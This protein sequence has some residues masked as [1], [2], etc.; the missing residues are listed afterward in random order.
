MGR[1]G[2]NRGLT[3]LEESTMKLTLLLILSF[4][5]YGC[6]AKKMAAKNA[7][8][9]LEY[10]IEKRLPLYAA[11]KTQLSKD[12]NKF[13]NEQKSFAKE[14]IPV[15]T[16]IQLDVNKVDTQ[17]DYLDS[18]YR[19]LALNFSKLM[20]KYMAPLDETQQKEFG[21]KLEAENQSLTRSRP[22]DRI[23][24]IYD[25][26]ETLFGTISDKQKKIFENEKSYIEERHKI[27]LSRREKLHDK[28]MA[29]YK[30]DLSNESRAKYFYEAFA[31]YQNNYPE[32][33]K[34]KELIKSIIP[35]L[36][37]QQRQVFED[38]TNDLKEILNYYL[39]THY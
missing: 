26:F 24:K 33:P 35:T 2:R 13:L 4:I 3:Q 22:D 31:E 16:S 19:K 7:D 10:Q 25:R 17:Y 12:V 30:M 18:L 11:Q 37:A 38:K 36:T 23:D 29:I 14:A 27:R 20:S 5:G 32:S 6:A 15:I 1:F 8:V 34:N 39:D 9:M 21:E 28:F